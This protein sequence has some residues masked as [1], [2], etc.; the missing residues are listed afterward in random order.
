MRESSDSPTYFLGVDMK[1][2]TAKMFK[3]AVKSGK[4]KC[5]LKFYRKTLK[6]SRYINLWW[7]MDFD[8]PKPDQYQIF[9]DGLHQ[10]YVAGL[11]AAKKK[12]KK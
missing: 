8:S 2:R 11:L 12:E 1:S 3:R 9:L 7:E 6:K 5:S 10:G 4:V